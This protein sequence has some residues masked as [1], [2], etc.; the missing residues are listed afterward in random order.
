MGPTN[1]TLAFSGGNIDDLE[2][3]SESIYPVEGTIGTEILIPGTGFGIKKGKVVIE[4]ESLG[5]KLTLK[6]PKDGWTDMLIKGTISKAL[7]PGVYDVTV[8]PKG[9][10]P[11][12]YRGSFSMKRPEIELISKPEGKY[13]DIVTVKGKYFGASGWTVQMHYIDKK[14]AKKQWPCEVTNSKWDEATGESEAE[15]RVPCNL[16]KYPHDLTIANKVGFYVEERALTITEKVT[17]PPGESGSGPR[18]DYGW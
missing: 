12:V 3:T 5:K 17:C 8:L 7:P 15:F 6:L 1:S 10:L 4:S 14:N 16:S 18:N 13:D 11:I 9:P 2:V